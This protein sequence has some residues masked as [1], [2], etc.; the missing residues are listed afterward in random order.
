MLGNDTC[1]LI[2]SR[3]ARMRNLLTRTQKC[4]YLTR[5]ALTNDEFTYFAKCYAKEFCEK[6][7]IT[8]LFCSARDGY[9][10]LDWLE[11]KRTVPCITMLFL[12]ER[13]YHKFQPVLND[14][15]IRHDLL[16]VFCSDGLIT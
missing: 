6:G 8:K 7:S 2:M 16:V 12:L 4:R 5:W 15:E 9:D 10:L 3:F 1:L 14:R 11:K 13:L